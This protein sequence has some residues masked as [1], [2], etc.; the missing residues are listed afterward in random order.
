MPLWL[1]AFCDQIFSVPQYGEGANGLS[2][3]EAWNGGP[4]DSGTSSFRTDILK[5]VTVCVFGS[6]IGMLS[7]EYSDE[8]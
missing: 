7:L 3:A 1:F 4:N 2:R 5:N 8:P 6:R